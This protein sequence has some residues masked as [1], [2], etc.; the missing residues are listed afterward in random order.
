MTNNYNKLS[1]VKDNK[2]M[3][4][5]NQKITKKKN[6]FNTSNNKLSYEEL[7]KKFFYK[8][9][10]APKKKNIFHDMENGQNLDELE[11]VYNENK[12]FQNCR[13]KLLKQ[14]TEILKTMILHHKNIPE[15]WII[16]YTYKNLLDNV[17]KDPIVLSYAIASKEI[18]KKRS[19]AISIDVDDI[20]Y[21]Y[22]LSPK[23][24]KFISYINP[25]SRNFD[26]SLKKHEIRKEYG[27]SV[28]KRKNNDQ[29]IYTLQT[30]TKGNNKLKKKF[31]ININGNEK[32]ELPNIFGNKK[33]KKKNENDKNTEDKNE[34]TMMTSLYYDENKL[35]DNKYNNEKNKD[36][37]DNKSQTY[38]HEENEK[39]EIN[40]QKI[41]LPDIEF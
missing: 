24:P 26:E 20:K 30:E 27:Y 8:L 14:K 21:H 38:S 6:N 3:E 16:N 25:Y 32:K 23:E 2:K 4:K 31:F 34:M 39:Q 5:N 40:K 29:N 17:M 41:E 9:N 37:D 7:C 18:Y 33:K 35:N 13:N 36:N 10:L 28:K 19:T 12:A 1:R 22:S 15:R 11:Q